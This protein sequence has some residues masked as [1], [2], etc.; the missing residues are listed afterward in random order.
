MS[1]MG[2]NRMSPEQIDK[3]TQGVLD[4]LANHHGVFGPNESTLL[5]M[6]R[7]WDKDVESL[8]KVVDDLCWSDSC[9]GF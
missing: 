4:Y 2:P 7:Y 8:R 9:I 1:V 6:R 5:K 3:I